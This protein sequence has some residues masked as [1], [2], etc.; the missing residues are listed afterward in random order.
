MNT[1]PC[2]KR[3]ENLNGEKDV[4][5]ITDIHENLRRVELYQATA[6]RFRS[7]V[8]GAPVSTTVVYAAAI[9]SIPAGRDLF[10]RN[11]LTLEYAASKRITKPSPET[12]KQL[13]ADA[14][15]D[16]KSIYPD[17]GKMYDIWA[18]MLDGARADA[19]KVQP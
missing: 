9:E 17:G 15:A 7:Y 2:G 11:L 13:Y 4:A 10:Q 16:L 18:Y 14:Q 3:G 5:N 6:H 8:G 19:E 1:R 12:I